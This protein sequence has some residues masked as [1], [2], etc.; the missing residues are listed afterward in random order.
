MC[1]LGGGL[2]RWQ[3][4]ALVGAHALVVH[5]IKEATHLHGENQEGNVVGRY[6]YMWAGGMEC[7][8][9]RE[10]GREAHAL[11]AHLIKE[12]PKLW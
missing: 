4:N 8:G 11:A 1:V 3:L 6:E 7:P 5:V 9:G 10:D 12:P 2:R